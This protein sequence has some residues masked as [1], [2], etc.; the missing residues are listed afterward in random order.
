MKDELHKQIRLAIFAALK[1]LARL[2]LRT[3]IGFREFNEVAKSAFVDVATKD[4]GLR[5]RPTNISRV[6]VMTGLTRKEVKKIREQIEYGYGSVVARSTPL[7]EVL[8]RWYSDKDFLDD[9]GVPRPLPFDGDSLSFAGIV[10]KTGGDIPP[11]AMRTEL[12]RI[13]AIRTTEEGLLEPV[14]RN[15]IVEELHD[16]VITGLVRGIRPIATTIAHNTN[17]TWQGDTWV[18]RTVSTR[19]VRPEDIG[20]VRRISRD[21]LN[22][23]TESIDDLYSAYES[24]HADQEG[25]AGSAR[26]I[27]VG[28]FYFE[29][30]I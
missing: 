3:G 26:M 16:R 30:D 6:A 2:L 14:K 5:G 7:G 29:D 18:Q 10:K 28:V 20:R 4:Y 11:G 19:F 25:T 27:G 15:V 8:H 13:G 12:K 21:R 22:E 9:M 23:F 1:P 17:P 24:I